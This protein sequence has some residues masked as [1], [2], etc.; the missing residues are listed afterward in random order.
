[1]RVV[2]RHGKKRKRAGGG[3]VEDD[4][5]LPFYRGRGGAAGNGGQRWKMGTFMAAVTRSGGGRL[6]LIEEGQSY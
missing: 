6:Q 1:V 5:A 2:L 3:A 4:G